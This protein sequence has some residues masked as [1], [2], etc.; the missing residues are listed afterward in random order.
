MIDSDDTLD[1][2]G[3]FHELDEAEDTLLD[4][5][6]R[7]AEEAIAAWLHSRSQTVAGE[8]PGPGSEIEAAP[9]TIRF[10]ETTMVDGDLYMDCLTMFLLTQLDFELEAQSAVPGDDDVVLPDD[11]WQLD[12]DGM[13]PEDFRERLLRAQWKVEQQWRLGLH[14]PPTPDDDYETQ[15]RRFFGALA[16]RGV[17]RVT[18]VESYENPFEGMTPMDLGD[19]PE[20]LDD[21]CA[22]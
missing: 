20:D 15:S 4:D 6:D 11:R 9:V 10:D 16:E 1:G 12:G 5:E 21:D 7:E 22:M 18:E 14:Q 19:F 17:C 3:G 13:V 8:A 2:L